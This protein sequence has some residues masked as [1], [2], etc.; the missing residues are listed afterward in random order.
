MAPKMVR[1]V[2]LLVPLATLAACGPGVPSAGPTSSVSSGSGPSTALAEPTSAGTS[3]SPVGQAG[4]AEEVRF[5]PSCGAEE[6][7]VRPMETIQLYCDAAGGDGVEISE[8]HYWGAT[9][10]LAD[11][12]RVVN[13][14]DP[15]CAAG[16]TK[17][18]P[19]VML[20]DRVKTTKRGGP[21]FTRMI[22]ADV[23]NPHGPNSPSSD[24]DP[25]VDDKR[26]TF[27]R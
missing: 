15:S 26:P 14:C 5:D 8:W 10:A 17:E 2:A 19:A 13:T 16:N 4:G 18:Y 23:K 20:L 12:V 21:Q 3:S 1:A 24:D 7:Q 27:P 9:S 6:P 22:L 11:V 25:Y